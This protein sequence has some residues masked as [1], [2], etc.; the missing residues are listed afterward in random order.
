MRNVGQ[1]ANLRPIAN[2]PATGRRRRLR[3]IPNWPQVNNLPHP[4]PL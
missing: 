3:P 4:G 1:V 2:R